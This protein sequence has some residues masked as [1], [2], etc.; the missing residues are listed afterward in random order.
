MNEFTTVRQIYNYPSLK[1]SDYDMICSRHEKVQ[2]A[3]GDFLLREGQIANEY[4]CLEEGLIRAYANSFEGNE[5]T[6]AFFSPG[7]IV[8]E[9]ASL[10]LRSQT[11]EN[12][13]AL[14]D[15]TCWKISFSEFQE[16]FQT[17]NAFTEWGRTWMARAL[18]STK[19][20]SLAMITDSATDRY[21]ALLS[22]NPE[23]L[24]YAPLKH[25]A[26]YLGITDT[27]LSRIR[28]YISSK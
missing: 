15:C 26:S 20:R 2:I 17:I 9:V 14:T 3:K 16:L 12:I 28:K 27:S 7:D 18:F 8:I 13:Q 4:F 21:L 10:F 11:K 22:E 6:T 24:H 1:T 23:I 19:E 5:V 25:V